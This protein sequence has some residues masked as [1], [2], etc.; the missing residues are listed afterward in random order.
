ML[1]IL[2]IAILPALMIV[3]AI[4]DLDAY[5]IPNWL[6]GLLAILF[7]PM[8]YFTGLPLIDFGYHFLAGI[9]LFILGYLLFSFGLF[10]GG[11]AK[12]MAA[13]G[14]WFGTAQALQFLFLTALAG[15]LMAAG[16]AV[17][18]LIAAYIDFHGPSE[19]SYL[20]VLANKIKLKLPYGLAL[21]VGAI[22]AFPKTWWVGVV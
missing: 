1:H 12:L 21:A 16:V 13:A 7:L 20:R 15:G 18:A 9:A 10:G 19:Q 11:D 6:T 22:L 8:A 17:W 3:A 5:R 14:L 2:A 4:S